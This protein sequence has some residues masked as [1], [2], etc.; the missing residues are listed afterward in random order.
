M[1]YVGQGWE[2]PVTLPFKAFSA[3]DTAQFK[4][5][6][7][8]AYTRFFGRPIDGPDI[9]IVSWSVRASSPLPP[10]ERIETVGASYRAQEVD[11][12]QVFD[13]AAGGFVEAGIHPRE[14]LQVGAR[15]DGPAIIVERETSTFVTSNFTATVQPDGCLLVVRR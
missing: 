8:E 3:A 7:E 4:T 15:V 6:F 12:R 11:R 9:E 13:V 1:R 10:V 2:I 14:E 5:L